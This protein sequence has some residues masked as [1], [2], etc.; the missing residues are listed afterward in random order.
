MSAGGDVYVIK[1][2]TLQDNR[3]TVPCGVGPGEGGKRVPLRVKGRGASPHKGPAL[4]PPSP[5]GGV[6]VYV[7]GFCVRFH[8]E[9]ACHCVKRKS[10][11]H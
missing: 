3:L 9:I 4:G 11:N 7:L 5:A 1:K 2:T 6:S 8:S 10:E